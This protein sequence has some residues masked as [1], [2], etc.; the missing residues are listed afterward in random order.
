MH[1]FEYYVGYFIFHISFYIRLKSWLQKFNGPHHDLVHNYETFISQVT[2]NRLLFTWIFIFSMWYQDVVWTWLY[3][4]ITRRV[5][6]QN[7]ELLTFR[8][9]PDSPP[10]FGGVRV[11]D[12]FSCLYCGV[13]FFLCLVYPLFPLCL[14]CFLTFP[15]GFSSVYLISTETQVCKNITEYLLLNIQLLAKKGRLSCWI[16]QMRN[17]IIVGS[18]K[19][20]L[21]NVWYHNN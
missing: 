1:T 21:V 7:R 9:H 20:C 3:I 12:R 13:Y 5:F 17:S 6:Y 8:E 11:A 15:S 2:V 4:W 10:V 18:A 19:M 16:N 14:D